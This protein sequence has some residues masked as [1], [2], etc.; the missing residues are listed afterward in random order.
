MRIDNKIQKKQFYLNFL[1]IIKGKWEEEKKQIIIS[2]FEKFIVY[3]IMNLK[4]RKNEKS[5]QTGT[6]NK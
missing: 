2:N 5:D 6:C 4:E 3:D 1:K